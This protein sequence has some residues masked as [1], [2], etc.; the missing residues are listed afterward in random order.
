MPKKRTGVLCTPFP[1]S[2]RSAGEN[3]SLK[4]LLDWVRAAADGASLD[5]RTVNGAYDSNKQVIERI[6]QLIE[7]ADLVVTVVREANANAFFEAG[8][9]MGLGKPVLYVVRE[10]EAVPFNARGVEHFS[11][12]EIDP[13]T[14]KQLSLIH[15][16]EPTRPY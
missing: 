4:R 1:N 11:F 6:Y 7:D 5:L 9:A 2:D 13:G 8:Y 3:E 16:S 15:I 14:G 12:H 10:G